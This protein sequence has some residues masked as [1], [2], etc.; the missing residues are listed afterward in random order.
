MF[1]NGERVKMSVGWGDLDFC[2]V[3]ADLVRDNA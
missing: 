3:T 2:C 1:E